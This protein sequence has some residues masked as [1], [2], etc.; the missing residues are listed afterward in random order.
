MKGPLFPKAL[1]IRVVI[2]TLL[3]AIAGYMEVIQTEFL[4]GYMGAMLVGALARIIYYYGFA[5]AAK[6]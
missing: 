4:V 5:K 3:I 1:L 6:E 2:F